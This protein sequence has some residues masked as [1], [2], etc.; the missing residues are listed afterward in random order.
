M[1]DGTMAKNDSNKQWDGHEGKMDLEKEI[2]ATIEIGQ[3]LGVD[4]RNRV[5]RFKIKSREQSAVEF[6][7]RGKGDEMIKS[8]STRMEITVCVLD[9]CLNLDHEEQQ[10]P[11]FLSWEQATPKKLQAKKQK[12]IIQAS[13]IDP[14]DI[15]GVEYELDNHKNAAYLIIRGMKS[16]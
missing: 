16:A 4:L 11:F 14:T 1:E 2:K 3:V 5:E 10:H 12:I 6:C 9:F 7:I 13:V 15:A 8:K